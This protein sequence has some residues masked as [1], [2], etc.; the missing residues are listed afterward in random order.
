MD[1]NLTAFLKVLDPQDNSTGGGTASA[2]A[3]A[4]A[5]GLIAM[6]ARLSIGKP[7]MASEEHYL[8]IASEAGVLSD[9]LFDGGRIDS[10]AF[11]SVGVAYRLPK[12]TDEEKRSRTAAIQE[13]WVQATRVPLA[14]AEACGRLLELAD[15][16]QRKFNQNAASDLECAQYL[17][18]A[19]VLGCIANVHINLPSI[20][21]PDVAKELDERARELKDLAA[22]Q[23]RIDG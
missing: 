9:A 1:E 19:G 5:G 18:R 3:G 11:E 13:A 21:D 12:N 22:A 17:A 8:D 4:M 14:N 16:L 23:S 20:K 6:V 7:D 10:Q 15:R 2:V